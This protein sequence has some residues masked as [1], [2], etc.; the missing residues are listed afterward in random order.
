M[1]LSNAELVEAL[2]K[3]PILEI[4]ELVKAL[5]QLAFAPLHLLGLLG[6]RVVVAQQVEQAVHDEQPELV[7]ERPVVI[8][9]LPARDRR[10]HDDVAQHDR[11]IHRLVR[12]SR[13]APTFVG[14]TAGRHVV[15]V[16]REREHVGGAVLTEEP[17]VEISD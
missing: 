3:K 4:V 17:A 15:V 2:S 6:L 10:A 7:V 9:R 14:A 11:R 16:D 5:E 12:R 13:P 1:S 8:G